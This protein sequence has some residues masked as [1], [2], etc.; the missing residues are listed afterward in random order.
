MDPDWVTTEQVI[1][2]CTAVI[3]SRAE[4][5]LDWAHY[6]NRGAAYF[7]KGQYARAIQDF[8]EALRLKPGNANALAGMARAKKA[9]NDGAK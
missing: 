8:D 5:E 6:T 4:Q 9:L 1:E 3:K 7:D 2:G